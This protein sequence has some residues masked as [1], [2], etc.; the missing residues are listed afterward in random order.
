MTVDP[1]AADLASMYSRSSES[2]TLGSC[3]A[4]D[5]FTS[6]EKSNFLA[7]D[8]NGA[9]PNH[10]LCPSSD[11]FDLAI[12]GAP[13]HGSHKYLSLRVKANGGSASAPAAPARRL[14]VAESLQ[15]YVFQVGVYHGSVDFGEHS[16]SPIKYS[17]QEIA[18]L[19]LESDK[20][21]MI[22]VELQENC[23]KLNDYWYSA[24][25]MGLRELH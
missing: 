19:Q 2:W 8:Q 24:D 3:N 12:S 25:I 23:L 10:V 1:E 20:T 16:G 7:F 18:L 15:R 22:K 14:A 6:E 4:A 21:K 5:L 9:R 13:T 17:V 11:N